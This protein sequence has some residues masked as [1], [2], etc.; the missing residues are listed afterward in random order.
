MTARGTY[1]VCIVMYQ[2][3]LPRCVISSCCQD[4]SSFGGYQPRCFIL[5]MCYK[6]LLPR[7]VIFRWLPAKMFHLI[8]RGTHCVCIVMYQ[9]LLP[10]CVI[11]SCRQDVSSFGGYLPRCFILLMCYKFLLP[12]C[13]IFRWLPAKMFHFIGRGTHCVCIVMYQL[14]L[15]RCVIS[16]CCQDVSSFGG[17]LPRC[18]ILL[19][20]YKFLLPRCVIF[21]WLPAKMFHLIGRGMHRVCIVMYQLLLPR[22]VISSCCQDV[23]SFGGYLP[24]CFI[25]LMCHQFLLPRCVIF[26]WLP[27][28]MFHLIGRGMYCV[29]IVTYR[30]LLP[31]CV[32]SSCCQD[33]S[34]FG[35]YLP[36][37][38]I[39]LMC[40]LLVA[41]CQEV[42]SLVGEHNV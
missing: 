40:H 3:L 39:L 6:F 22:C 7:C 23:S 1:C 17:Y 29:C 21:R 26:R 32:I 12:R 15:P 8:G 38:F 35:G 36:R 20:C 34:S 24:R 31:R 13:V 2:L 25:L 19:M 28:K 4:V 42:S 27:A 11:S 9:L 10:R 37:C 18:F 16:S 41:T 5:L 14:L 30:L 33:V